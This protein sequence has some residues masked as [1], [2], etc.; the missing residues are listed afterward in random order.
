MD[1]RLSGKTAVVTGGSRGIG[2]AIAAVLAEQGVR[3][4][5]GA[6]RAP[7]PPVPGT[8]AVTA[9]LGTEQGARDLAGAALTELGAVDVLVNNVGGGDGGDG[10]TSGFLGTSDALWHATFELNLFSAVRVT[11]HLLPSLLDQRGSI[12]T[13]SSNAARTPGAGP[14]PYAVAKAALT[15]FA[16]G[17]DAEYGPRGVRVNTVSP[18]PVR[19]DLWEHPEGYGAA[20]ARSLGIPLDDLLA[21]LP[22][23]SG[24]TTGR[25]V[26]PLEV[27]HLVAYLASP[28]A[29]SVA[30]ADLLI[31]GGAT[32]TL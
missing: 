8:T 4:V 12:V 18:G 24:M 21:G 30:G 13:V 14:L 27:A 7:D 10:Q 16:K 1:L 22:E 5:V 31:D 3:V 28:L 2:R 25:L 20:L 11:R 17:L 32:R 9:D 19:T 23:A 6:R 29:A 15:A 26:E